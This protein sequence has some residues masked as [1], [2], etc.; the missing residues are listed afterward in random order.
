MPLALTLAGA[1]ACAD[2]CDYVTEPLDDYFVQLPAVAPGCAPAG[3]WWP[4]CDGAWGTVVGPAV[5]AKRRVLEYYTTVDGIGEQ[6][7][8]EAIYAAHVNRTGFRYHAIAFDPTT[9]ITTV[10]ATQY[11]CPT[12]AGG[13]PTLGAAYIPVGVHRHAAGVPYEFAV[14]VY[15]TWVTLAVAIAFCVCLPR[16]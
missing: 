7:V 1:I 9:R 11:A 8:R 3:C 6:T 10:D 16:R 13:A 14:A 15:T 4:V 5:A 12:F 2:A